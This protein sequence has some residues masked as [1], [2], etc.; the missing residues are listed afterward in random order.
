MTINNPIYIHI[1]V[2]FLWAVVWFVTDLVLT[3]IHVIRRDNDGD[4]RN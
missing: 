2:L 3:L 4:D 1:L